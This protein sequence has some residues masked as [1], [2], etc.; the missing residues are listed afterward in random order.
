M[1]FKLDLHVH[2]CFSADAD[3]SIER[4]VQRAKIIGLN[5]IAITDHDT[6]KGSI[7]AK[8]YVKKKSIDLMIIPGTEVTTSKGHL[9][10]LGSE[11]D[12]PPHLTLEKTIE[13]ARKRGCFVIVPHPFHPFR[14]GIGDFR[15]LD[16]DAVEVFNSRY[17]TGHSNK[18]ADEIAKRN[19]YPPVAGSDAHMVQAVGFGVTEVDADNNLDSIFDGIKRGKTTLNQHKTPLATYLSQAY[20]SALGRFQR[21]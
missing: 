8:E 16:I 7:A 10:V 2:T 1:G 19:G 6:V 3:N 14:H 18:K 5:G 4:I 21:L 9:I 17:I 12:I 13:I 15:N 20:N 11:K